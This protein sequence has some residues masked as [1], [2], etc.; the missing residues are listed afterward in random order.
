M[1]T[2][3]N[4]TEICN[5]IMKSF[6]REMLKEVPAERINDAVYRAWL[7]KQYA[8]AYKSMPTHIRLMCGLPEEMIYFENMIRCEIAI[9]DFRDTKEYIKIYDNFLEEIERKNEIL[10]NYEKYSQ[11][12]HNVYRLILEQAVI[13]N[14]SSETEEWLRENQKS[15]N[16]IIEEKDTKKQEI[17]LP[18][19][20]P[21][22]WEQAVCEKCPWIIPFLIILQIMMIGI[23]VK[24]V[25]IELIDF[26]QE[27]AVKLEEKEDIFF[28]ES[29]SAKIY[30]EPTVHSDIVGTVYYSD[31]VKRMDSINMWDKIFYYDENGELVV[32]WIA[33]KKLISFREWK[34]Y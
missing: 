19:E 17:I 16:I 12:Y 28:V 5:L 4:I 1:Q 7:K 3:F 29:D 25:G 6:E 18:S 11:F 14:E 9:E 15:P 8:K 21:K 31:K 20:Y 13:N 23:A 34:K 26:G 27:V 24:E 2:Q 10:K 30:S 32:G 22:V 33:S